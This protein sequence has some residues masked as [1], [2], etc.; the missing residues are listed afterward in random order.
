MRF[1]FLLCFIHV[2]LVIAAASNPVPFTSTDNIDSSRKAAAGYILSADTYATLFSG[3]EHE[4]YPLHYSNL[5][6]F[7]NSEYT[8]G[9]LYSG[10][11]IY[12]NVLMKLDLFRDEL[13]ISPH[14][15]PFNIVT[16]AD[17]AQLHGTTIHFVPASNVQAPSGYVEV[18]HNGNRKL[19]RKYQ[20]LQRQ[21]VES[22]RVVYR[23]ETLSAYW[24]LS[25]NQ[26]Y[27]ITR[28]ADLYPH[29]QVER[30]T[31]RHFVTEQQLNFR[32]NPETTLSRLMNY[33]DQP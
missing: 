24:L 19:Y 33:L 14:N 15:S 2:F 4:K 9:M 26:F 11:R 20:L 12:P 25:D 29:F 28:I 30:R 10:G 16:K 6:W 3:R 8:S 1:F 31:I 13:V 18:L 27:K 23:F 32:K 17:S 21:V 22:G 7:K 5:P